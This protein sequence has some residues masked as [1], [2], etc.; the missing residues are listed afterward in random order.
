M[1]QPSTVTPV[2]IYLGP[3][4]TAYMAT[5]PGCRIPDS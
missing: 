5:W 1:N 4:G 3:D 2:T